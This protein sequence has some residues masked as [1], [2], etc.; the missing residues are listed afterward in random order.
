MDVKL[1]GLSEG[2]QYIIVRT[3]PCDSLWTCDIT[4]ENYVERLLEML[5]EKYR[6]KL[7]TLRHEDWLSYSYVPVFD[8]DTQSE[9][10]TELE[11]YI[12]EK[13]AWC[14]KYGCD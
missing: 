4:D 2:R 3:Q 12:K 10:D 7:V 1:N 13:Q 14:D 8:T 9:W 5:P 6:D 11:D